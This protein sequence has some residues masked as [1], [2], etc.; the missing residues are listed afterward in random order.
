MCSGSFTRVLVTG[1]LG[2]GSDIG[3]ETGIRGL[4]TGMLGLGRHPGVVTDVSR[5]GTGV[6]GLGAG[7]LGLRTGIL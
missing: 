1:I 4:G 2:L 6:V 3:L 5:L 7:V